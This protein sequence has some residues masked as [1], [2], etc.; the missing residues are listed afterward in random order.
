MTNP[1]P[2]LQ[3]WS[4]SQVVQWYQHIRNGLG[5]CHIKSR[6]ILINLVWQIV[7]VL[8]STFIWRVLPRPLFSNTEIHGCQFHIFQPL[9][10]CNMITKI[11]YVNTEISKFCNM[12]GLNYNN[13]DGCQ[14][15]QT[16][17]PYYIRNHKL[18]QQVPIQEGTVHLHAKTMHYLV[19][20]KKAS[21]QII[22]IYCSLWLKYSEQP[23][24]CFH[25]W[26][27]CSKI[28][29]SVSKNDLNTCWSS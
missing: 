27:P 20:N 12:R 17:R 25:Y 10:L 18:N 16:S 22:W 28:Y 26:V 29:Q 9:S 1:H 4:I 13:N 5:G 19:N 11:N 21:K 6:L 15:L 14:H 8:P 2:R 7:N 23:N 3:E 24:F